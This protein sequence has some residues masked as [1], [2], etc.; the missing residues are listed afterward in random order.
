MDITRLM[1]MRDSLASLGAPLG[2]TE[3]VDRDEVR[4]AYRDITLREQYQME[5]PGRPRAS[6]DVAIRLHANESLFDKLDQRRAFDY[7]DTMKCDNPFFR[8]RKV[9]PTGMVP[10]ERETRQRLDRLNQ[11]LFSRAQGGDAPVL[12]FRHTDPHF[13]SNFSKP[14]PRVRDAGAGKP[15]RG[16]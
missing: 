10:T 13:L 1:Q 16:K 15:I 7:W 9:A 14:N 4:V 12:I 3:Q 11:Y 2:V 6:V 8:W 5:I